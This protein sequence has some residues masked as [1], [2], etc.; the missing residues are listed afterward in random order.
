M[1][2]RVALEE[3]ELGELLDLHPDVIAEQNITAIVV[4]DKAGMDIRSAHVG[5]CIDMRNEADG[6]ST[7]LTRGSGQR[8][9]N[10]AIL[11][12][13]NLFQTYCLQLL[14]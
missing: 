12:H 2:E 5:R 4:L 14:L 1:N 6:R 3:R 13:R 11:I 7:L 9:H 8:S 10:V